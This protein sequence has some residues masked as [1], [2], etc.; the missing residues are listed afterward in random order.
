[1]T[2]LGYRPAPL[3]PITDPRELRDVTMRDYLRA[4]ERSGR[5]VDM[6]EI[7]RTAIRHL[8]IVDAYNR[9][10]DLT[11]PTE[12]PKQSAEP[13]RFVAPEHPGERVA[14]APT[15]GIRDRNILHR[16]P[17]EVS[18]RWSHAIARIRRIIAGAS[19]GS[20]LAAGTTTAECPDL[21]LRFLRLWADFMTRHRESRHNPFRGYS[22]A[23]CARIFMRGVE[24][25]CDASSGRLGPWMVPK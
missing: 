25:I 16:N 20:S 13:R 6:V 12:K 10:I 4:A 14:V 5:P 1:M 18:M 19:A 8:E 21:A 7:Y 22:E 15:T 23:D 9:G 24:D 11:R 17:I 2:D 3:R